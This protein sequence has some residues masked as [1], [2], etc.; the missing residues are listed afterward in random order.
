MPLPEAEG[1]RDYRGEPPQNSTQDEVQN[2]IASEAAARATVEELRLA[3]GQAVDEHTAL[4]RAAKAAGAAG[5][6]D[7]DAGE[8][9]QPSRREVLKRALQE[10][11]IVPFY[12]PQIGLISGSLVGFEALAR[13]ITPDRETLLP[14][15]FLPWFERAGLYPEFSIHMV[16][17]I[18]QQTRRWRKDGFAVPPIS[19]NLPAKL[20]AGEAETEALRWIL[21]DNGMQRNDIK[22]EV[23]EAA[24]HDRHVSRIRQSIIRLSEDGAKISLDDF[25]TGYGVL[26]HLRDLPFDEVKIDVSLVSALGGDPIA[27]VAVE[28]VARVARTLGLTVAAEGIETEEQAH[29]VREVGCTLGQGIYF[30]APSHGE[31]ARRVMRTASASLPL[32]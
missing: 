9:E 17:T 3:L 32:A 7:P 26:R 13:W 6:P 19:I 5:L 12:Q 10:V 28:G 30:G 8:A 14:E 15:V 4:L 25:G 21:Y 20:L 24:F 16:E 23:T 2:L 1:N 18:L 11:R 29:F 22:F 31:V 27:E